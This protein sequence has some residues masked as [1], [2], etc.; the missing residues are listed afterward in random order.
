MNDYRGERKYLND[1]KEME[2]YVNKTILKKNI[3]IMRKR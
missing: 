1:E 3:L 2:K